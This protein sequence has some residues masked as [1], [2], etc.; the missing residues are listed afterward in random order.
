MI[1]MD[2]RSGS[3][4]WTSQATHGDQAAQAALSAKVQMIKDADKTN[5]SIA[6]GA[7]VAFVPGKG[8]V[9]R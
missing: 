1:G 6:Q 2:N 8:I 5:K 9:Q 3:T 4:L 7:H